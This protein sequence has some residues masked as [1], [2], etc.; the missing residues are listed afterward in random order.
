[1]LPPEEGPAP[2]ITPLLHALIDPPVAPLLPGRVSA[3]QLSALLFAHLLRGSPD[4]KALAR[5]I[6][7]PTDAA[8]ASANAGGFFV[9]ADTSGGAAAPAPQPADD[10]DEPQTLLQI[11]SEHLSLAFLARRRADT[12]EAEAREW[13]RLVVAYL[14]L[15]AQWLWEDPTS[16]REFLEAGALGMVS[17]GA[18]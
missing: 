8:L 10:E 17:A 12:S 15:L 13:D 3:T 1:M 4:S 18:R 5:A 16:V 6:V 7:P 2:P 11:L 9:P 14:S